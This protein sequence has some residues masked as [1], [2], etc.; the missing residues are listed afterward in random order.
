MLQF[1]TWAA[2]AASHT[3][4]H[5]GNDDTEQEEGSNHAPYDPAYQHTIHRLNICPIFS[6]KNNNQSLLHNNMNVFV[7]FVWCA[8]VN[9]HNY[10]S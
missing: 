3:H 1:D 9:H 6:C 10:F 4:Y 8:F 7:G 2:C 5:Y